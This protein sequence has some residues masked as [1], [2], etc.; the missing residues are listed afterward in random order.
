[1]SQIK[2]HGIDLPSENIISRARRRAMSTL[3]VKQQNQHN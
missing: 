2:S 1:M 3:P